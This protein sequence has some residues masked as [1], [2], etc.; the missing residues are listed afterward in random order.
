MA[1]G[2]RPN[3][4][5]VVGDEIEVV[6]KNDPEWWEVGDFLSSFTFV[7]F[8]LLE[9]LNA[10][11]ELQWSMLVLIYLLIHVYRDGQNGRGLLAIF[12]KATW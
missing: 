12:L 3:L 11:F 1:P 9:T 6:N 8:V 7:S 5:F 4:S 10:S 2:G